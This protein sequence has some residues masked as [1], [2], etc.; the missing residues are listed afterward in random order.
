MVVFIR[1]WHRLFVEGHSSGTG[2]HNVTSGVGLVQGN[3]V[4]CLFV[5]SSG[6]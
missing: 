2:K 5:S 3:T 6:F 1:S 4:V